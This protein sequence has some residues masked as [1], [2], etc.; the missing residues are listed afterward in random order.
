MTPLLMLALAAINRLRGSGLSNRCVVSLLAGAS[1]AL[2]D[3]WVRGDLSHAGAVFLI[4]ALGFAFW[5]IFGWG[6]YFAAFHGRYSQIESEIPWIDRLGEKVFPFDGNRDTNLNRGAFCMALR[7]LYFYPT[8][9][10]L[11]FVTTPWALAIGL[12]CILQ[13]AAY[14][15]M[16]WAEEP[17]AVSGAEWLTGALFGALLAS[18]LAG[19]I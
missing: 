1:C 17:D 4:V 19:G 16:R 12:L 14:G 18:A 9:I 6:N 10:A 5:T 13:G 2:A 3:L 11:S 8:F 15:A 7:G